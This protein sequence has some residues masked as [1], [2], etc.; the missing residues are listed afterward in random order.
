MDQLVFV[1]LIRFSERTSRKLPK[2]APAQ[3]TFSKRLKPYLAGRDVRGTGHHDGVGVEKADGA[4]TTGSL[5][6][7]G[8]AVLAAQTQT[9]A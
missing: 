9:A 1:V 4:R 5:P 3:Y 8:C 2:N 6:L 7:L